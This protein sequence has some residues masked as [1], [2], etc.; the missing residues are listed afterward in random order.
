MEYVIISVILII[1]AILLKFALDIKIKDIKNLKKLAFDKRKNEILNKLP[2]NEEIA[3][4]IL[5]SLNNN[6]TKIKQSDNSKDTTSVYVVL[7]D[8]II[9]ANIK[10]T[11][12]RVQTIAHEC[13]HSMQNKNILLFNFIFTN[14]YNLFFIVL[15]ILKLFSIINSMIWL[16]LFI[17]AGTIYYVVRAYLET[18]A[19]IKAKYV[20]KEYMQESNLVKSSEIEEI[21]TGYDKI[22]KTG[23]K[24]YLYRLILEVLIRTFIFSIICIF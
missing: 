21:I 4:T 6:H 18:D 11:F 14:L 7:T 5:N 3:K 12:T 22:N 8:S 13:I 17:L 19:M 9:I 23:I 16:I 15:I 1:I 24:L 10:N 2:E 20:A